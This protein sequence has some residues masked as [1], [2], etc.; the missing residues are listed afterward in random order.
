VRFNAPPVTRSSLEKDAKPPTADGYRVSIPSSARPPAPIVRYLIPAFGWQK[1]ATSSSRIGNLLRVY[2][3]R[4]WFESGGGELLGVVVAPAGSSLPATLT[5]FV[6]GYGRDPVADSNP[7]STA[8]VTD[9]TLAVASGKSLVLQEAAALGLKKTPTVD[10]AGHRVSWDKSRQL[11]FADIEVNPGNAYFPFVKLALVRYQPGSLSGLELSRVVQ[12][13]FIQV[14][15][16]RTVS[17]AF[18]SSRIVDVAVTGPAFFGGQDTMRAYVQ[19][20]GFKTS[21][22]SL[23]WVTVPSEATGTALKVTHTTLSD[24]T[25]TGRVTLPTARG[26][27]RYRVLVVEFEE[28]AVVETGSL[29][30][31]SG[32]ISYLDAIE[33]T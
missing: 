1:T 11:W 27:K 3:G 24:W 21:D 9:F 8:T 2:L 31:L 32:R 6:S 25:W 4:P 23:E 30:D 22:P 13:D 14:A 5:P 33:I 17:L 20:I 18:P 15:T 28:H 26:T 10:V 19:E 7:V 29:P 12:A 16:D